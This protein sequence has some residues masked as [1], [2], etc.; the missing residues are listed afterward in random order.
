MQN[1]TIITDHPAASP[2]KGRHDYEN[3][4]ITLRRRKRELEIDRDLFDLRIKQLTEEKPS[5]ERDKP[6]NGSCEGLVLNQLIPQRETL[7]NLLDLIPRTLER[8]LKRIQILDQKKEKLTQDIKDKKR[9]IEMWRTQ[10]EG[11]NSEPP[12]IL[13][14]VMREVDASRW[15]T[16]KEL[17]RLESDKQILVSKLEQLTEGTNQLST[18]EEDLRDKLQGT[19]SE[20]LN[21]D[22]QQKQ[23]SCLEVDVERLRNLLVNATEEKKR[24]DTRIEREQAEQTKLT[25]LNL[26]LSTGLEGLSPQSDKL[27][28]LKTKHEEL[29]GYIQEM[30]QLSSQKDQILARSDKVR[31]CLTRVGVVSEGIQRQY[32]MTNRRLNFLESIILQVEEASKSKRVHYNERSG[33]SKIDDHIQL[34][35]KENSERKMEIT[36]L[37]RL[38]QSEFLARRQTDELSPTTQLDD[39]DIAALEIRKIFRDLQNPSDSEDS[40]RESV[41]RKRPS[42]LSCRSRSFSIK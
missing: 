31:E 32:Q 18:K 23:V 41:L 27:D 34:L 42:A 36:A 20:L 29:I 11:Y 16:E 17:N 15:E 12:C 25:Q 13:S 9:L 6:M 10:I 14:N 4:I 22:E 19:N 2:S 35:R 37:K 21:F 1:Q 8:N 26:S 30:D 3:E 38:Y 7:R 39:V 40:P 28:R 24:L 5:K 33:L